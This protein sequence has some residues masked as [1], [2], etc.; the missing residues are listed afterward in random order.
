MTKE[1]LYKKEAVIFAIIC[2][3]L[4]IVIMIGATIGWR[5]YWD[6][7]KIKFMAQWMTEKY[8]RLLLKW[9]YHYK[10]N[11]LEEFARVG[12]ESDWNKNC[13]GKHGERSYYQVLPR[14]FRALVNH[15]KK[16]ADDPTDI[17]E[18]YI[19]AGNLHFAAM[20]KFCG[21]QKRWDACEIYNIG[22]GGYRA[23]R[24]NSAYVTRYL[25]KLEYVEAEWRKYKKIF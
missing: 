16:M 18:L 9:S 7:K 20:R 14:T 2:S 6:N 23:G 24:K 13:R 12:T 4:I 19:I 25:Q 3:V 15:A 22:L 5:A 1:A 10:N 8:A 17:H 21:C 11:W